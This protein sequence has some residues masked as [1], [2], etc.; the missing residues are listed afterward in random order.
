MA[1]LSAAS[2]TILVVF[3]GIAA[4]YYPDLVQTDLSSAGEVVL[5]GVAI[6]IASFLGFFVSYL[7]LYLTAI[8][9]VGVLTAIERSLAPRVM[10]KV[11]RLSG[12]DKLSLFDRAT[13]WLFDIPDVLDTKTL[14]M[15]VTEPRTRV[16]LSDL[17]T[18][19]FWQLL[20]GFVLGIYISFNPFISDRSP[21]ALLSLFSLLTSASLLFP[22][23]I[24][25]WFLLKKLG[26]SIT[27]QTKHFTLYNGLR[28]RMFQSYFAVGTIFILVRVSF[29][30]IA[31]ALDV[32]VAAFAT[33][34]VVLLGSS[35]V[36]TFVYLNYFENPLAEDIA[37]RL[38]G[39]EVKVIERE[40]R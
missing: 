15:S 33:F 37:R 12:N 29:Q 23:L 24:L 14:S 40:P 27:G 10:K 34:M 11:S 32:Y 16:T 28:S 17:K 30:E 1:V 22:F 36:S 19:V 26:V 2:A 4:I 8:G 25:P 35:L 38:R 20:F 31:V 3:I 39:T 13:R 18:P 7:V 6:A 9:A 21:A 5:V